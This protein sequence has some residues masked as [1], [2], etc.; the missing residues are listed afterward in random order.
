MKR[1][2]LLLYLLL[3]SILLCLI[4]TQLQP[5]LLRTLDAVDGS[6]GLR[7]M[8]HQCAGLRLTGGAVSARFPSADWEGTIGFFHVRYFVTR[9]AM[10]RDFC[11]GQDVWFGE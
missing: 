11:L 5:V 9:D 8:T 3:G 7:P 4:A 10:D 6:F 2:S 1:S